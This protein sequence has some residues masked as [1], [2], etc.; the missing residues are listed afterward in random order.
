M[1]KWYSPEAEGDREEEDLGMRCTLEDIVES[2]LM[3]SA[4]EASPNC[5]AKDRSNSRTRVRGMILGYRSM[6]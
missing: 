3:H 2:K 5:M 1:R 6:I 4:K